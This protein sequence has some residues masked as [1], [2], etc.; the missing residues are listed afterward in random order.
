MLE[1][2]GKFSPPGFRPGKADLMS[3]DRLHPELLSKA[4]KPVLDA[5]SAAEMP[6][7]LPPDFELDLP[8][9][10]GANDSWLDVIRYWVDELR[11]WRQYWGSGPH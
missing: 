11:W 8:V 1:F 6:I 9:L 4:P 2:Q 7:Y 10:P 5:D 3:T